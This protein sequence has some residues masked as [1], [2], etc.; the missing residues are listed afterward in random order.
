MNS[1]RIDKAKA[2]DETT[3][4]IVFTNQEVKRYDIRR[5]LELPM[6][7]LLRQPAFFKSFRIET[8]GYGLVWNEEIDISEHELWT[9]GVSV[10]D[11]ESVASDL[12]QH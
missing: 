11:S 10:L 7:S 9:N 1:P 5:L 6:F 4:V 3:L 2:V 8:G 12:A